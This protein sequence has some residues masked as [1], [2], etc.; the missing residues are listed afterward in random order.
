MEQLFVSLN[1]FKEKFTDVVALNK[2]KMYNL[3]FF[4]Y[5]HGGGAVYPY[6]VDSAKKSL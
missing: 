4:K 1:V 5:Y 6:T 2:S 3:T